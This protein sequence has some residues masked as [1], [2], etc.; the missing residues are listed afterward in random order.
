MSI[1]N[2][3]VVIE[4]LKSLQDQICASLEAADGSG[5]FVEDN[6]CL[7]YTSDAADE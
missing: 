2:I 6:C 1:I 7:L 3:N 5:K 4:F